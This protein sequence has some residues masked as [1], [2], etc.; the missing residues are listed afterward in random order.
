ML[1]KPKTFGQKNRKPLLTIALKISKTIETN[2]WALQIHSLVMVQ[3]CCQWWPEKNVTYSIAL[4]NLP[5]LWSNAK[6]CKG[7]QNSIKLVSKKEAWDKGRL[8]L[9]LK[10]IRCETGCLATDNQTST[11]IKI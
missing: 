1:R 4:K 2:G 10:F 7:G 9:F 8:K 11:L 5:S 6:K 3:R